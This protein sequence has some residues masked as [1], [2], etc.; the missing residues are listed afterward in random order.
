MVTILEPR[1][2]IDDRIRANPEL[3][4]AV[5][6]TM[7]YLGRHVSG[8]P[9]PAAIL[10]RFLP[11]DSSSLELLLSDTPDF[12]DMVARRV[13][14]VVDMN[15]EYT[16]EVGISSAWRSLLRFRSEKNWR[17]I[18]ELMRRIEIAAENERDG[19]E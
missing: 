19:T 17:R 13:F 1:V 14:R 18:D 4:K 6:E 9:L 2:E 8:V 7:A 15:D 16:R 3:L 11:L 5:T 12:S 10:W